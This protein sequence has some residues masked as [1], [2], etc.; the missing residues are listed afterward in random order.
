MNM[1]VFVCVA[2]FS[3]YAGVALAQDMKSDMIER[4]AD[5][6][7]HMVVYV[8]EGE[9]VDLT[10]GNSMKIVEWNT[11][12]FEALSK[13]NDVLVVARCHVEDHRYSA[14][15]RPRLDTLS[16]EINAM[17]EMEYRFNTAR[18]ESASSS[19]LFHILV[20]VQSDTLVEYGP[21]EYIQKKLDEYFKEGQGEVKDYAPI[22]VTLDDKKKRFM[23]FPKKY[24]RIVDTVDEVYG[25]FF[26]KYARSVCKE[27]IR[28]M[29]DLT[30]CM[31]ID[32]YQYAYVSVWYGGD[33]F[34]LVPYTGEVPMRFQF[35]D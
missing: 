2:I 26:L 21:G 25:A 35:L 15:P 23:P 34:Y 18:G 3:L 1:R 27:K 31:E 9:A 6:R 11:E 24:A 20:D 10:E 22:Y 19:Q 13:E 29:E 5:G 14:F 12:R 30:A 8:P 17:L 16:S 7:E 33:F 32:V 4:C 28:S